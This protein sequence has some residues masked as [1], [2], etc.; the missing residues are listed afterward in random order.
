MDAFIYFI[1]IIQ[2]N[3]KLCKYYNICY[4]S[5][6]RVTIAE[7]IDAF[8]YSIYRIQF[9]CKLCKETITFVMI[10]FHPISVPDSQD[11]FDHSIY[12]IQF[13]CKLCK[14]TIT[15]VM[16]IFIIF[17][18]HSSRMPF[19]WYLKNSFICRL[20]KDYNICYESFHHIS[21]AEF[22]DAFFCGI[23]RIHFKLFKETIT[24][25]MKIFHHI[26]DPDS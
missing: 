26:S 20:C 17:L 25:D 4:E 10:I 14:E 16:K 3:C 12:R 22:M 1:Y 11:A 13:K 9:K 24:F 5:F 6:H 18:F 23:C 21:V 15:F 2:F 19:L 7:F 8:F